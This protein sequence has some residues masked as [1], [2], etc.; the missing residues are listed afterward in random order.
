MPPA[1]PPNAP[2]TITRNPHVAGRHVLSPSEALRR[3][4]ATNSTPQI[5]ATDAC[6]VGSASPSPSKEV[7][8]LNPTTLNPTT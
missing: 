3:T 8:A 4:P 6:Q 1:E 2:P 7:I 5:E